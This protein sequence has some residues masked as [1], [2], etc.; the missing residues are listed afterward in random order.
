MIAHIV[1]VN[2][3]KKARYDV[4]CGNDG[5]IDT[6]SINLAGKATSSAVERVQNAAEQEVKSWE[7]ETSDDTSNG[8]QEH[9]P[10]VYRI[11]ITEHLKRMYN[12][13]VML[14]IHKSMHTG[15]YLG[16]GSSGS[17]VNFRLWRGSVGIDSCNRFSIRLHACFS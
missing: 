9:I 15:S 7:R 2:Y 5:K 14:C 6:E 1:V 11:S 13:H 12:D 16:N 4:E 3:L 8:A 10:V 17:I